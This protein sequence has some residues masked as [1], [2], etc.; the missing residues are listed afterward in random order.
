LRQLPAP[1]T[2]IKV[3]ELRPEVASLRPAALAASRAAAS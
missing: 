3:K 1:A 2:E